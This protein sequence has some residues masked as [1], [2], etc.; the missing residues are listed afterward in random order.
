M[1]TS[2]GACGSAEGS[3]SVA[4]TIGSELAAYPGLHV[5]RSKNLDRELVRNLYRLALRTSLVSEP[6]A[7]SL[8]RY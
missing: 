6:L 8:S 2:R 5:V 1:V 3:A 4:V 7:Q